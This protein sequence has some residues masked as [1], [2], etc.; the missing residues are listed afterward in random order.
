MINDLDVFNN[1]KDLTLLRNL[2]EIIRGGMAL[3]IHLYSYKFLTLWFFFCLLTLFTVVLRLFCL[4][5]TKYISDY[6]KK[7]INKLQLF[8]YSFFGSTFLSSKLI[9]SIFQIKIFGFFQVVFWSWEVNMLKKGRKN[10][11]KEKIKKLN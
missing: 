2:P 10:A 9:I 8:L 5:L 7:Y 4:F 3:L 11:S 1:I 6:Q